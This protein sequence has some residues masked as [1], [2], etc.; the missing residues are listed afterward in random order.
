MKKFIVIVLI[1]MLAITN[2]YYFFR[3]KQHN[4]IFHSKLQ[5]TN[6]IDPE[7]TQHVNTFLI[8]AALRG[9]HLNPQTIHIKRNNFLYLKCECDGLTI[10]TDS[11][12]L[13]DTHST[14]WYLDPEFLIYHELG[15]LLLK[16]EHKDTEIN[17]YAL[18]LMHTVDIIGRLDNLELRRLY[19][20][21]LF[22]S[23][24]T[25]ALISELHKVQYNPKREIVE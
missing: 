7:F 21:E 15:H 18:S 23:T 3:E 5:S 9:V 22:D 2:G 25:K 12:I 16:R 1:A 6:D 19:V 14:N 17:G 11:L 10:G 4:N 8:N 20:D 24:K 13:I